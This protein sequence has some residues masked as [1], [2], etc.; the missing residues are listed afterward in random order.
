MNYQ[1]KTKYVQ[2]KIQDNHFHT[3]SGQQ[4]DSIGTRK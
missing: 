4:K 3:E 1:N 2:Y